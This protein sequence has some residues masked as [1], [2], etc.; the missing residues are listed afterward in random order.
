[1]KTILTS[2]HLLLCLPHDLF[3]LTISYSKTMGDPPVWLY[4]YTLILW[5]SAPIVYFR[6]EEVLLFANI[7]SSVVT[8]E[9]LWYP[10]DFLRISQ[11]IPGYPTTY[12]IQY[13]IQL[14]LFQNLWILW[15]PTDVVSKKHLKNPPRP[16]WPLPL[17]APFVPK[18]SV[19]ATCRLGGTGWRDDVAEFLQCPFW[20]L[21]GLVFWRRNS[22]IWH[23]EWFKYIK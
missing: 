3:L 11:D 6:W 4:R 21:L 14:I 23:F 20:N 12:D 1:M 22:T 19:G 5:I 9:K 17:L 15:Y 8:T 10:D 7:P 18:N 2:L 13:D 16:M